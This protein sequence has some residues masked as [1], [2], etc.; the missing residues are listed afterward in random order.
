MYSY[1]NVLSVHA[2]CPETLRILGN[3]IQK[4]GNVHEDDDFDLHQPTL[5]DLTFQNQ[6]KR[7]RTPFDSIEKSE[8]ETLDIKSKF[9]TIAASR[10]KTAFTNK[11]IMTCK[12]KF[13]DF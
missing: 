13:L 1:E 2:I 8:F 11:T 4:S 3:W 10:P 5:D 12:S 9:N 6:T 7:M